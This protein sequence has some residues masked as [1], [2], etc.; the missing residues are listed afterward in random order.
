M[1]TKSLNIGISAMYCLGY[2]VRRDY[3]IKIAHHLL[4]FLQMYQKCAAASI[5]L[6][7]NRFP[8]K[9]KLHMVHH[10]V[11]RLL[12]EA[13]R[14]QWVTNPIAESVQMQEDYIGRPARMSRRVNPRAI[15]ERTLFR[16]LIASMEALLASDVDVRGLDGH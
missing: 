14:S 4:K 16:S 6:R 13:G 3:A 11:Q 12:S 10:C 5:Q 9:P 7:R 2:W 1:G 15:H 8:I